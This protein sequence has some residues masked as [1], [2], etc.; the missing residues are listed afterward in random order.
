MATAIDLQGIGVA[1]EQAIRC[2]YLLRSVTT[3]AATQSSAGGLLAGVGNQI[4]TA[5]IATAGH[6]VTLPVRGAIGDEVIINNITAN[7]GVL[8]PPPG[9]NVNGEATDASMI[10]AA[11]GSTNCILRAIKVSA[12]RWAV[13]SAVVT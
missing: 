3:T 13:F 10:I 2:G 5:N 8:F 4:I 11:Q 7:A 6:A 12:L 1:A 9:G